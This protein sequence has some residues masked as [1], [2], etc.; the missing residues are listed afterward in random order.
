VFTNCLFRANYA[1]YEGG[2]TWV[3]NHGIAMC[4]FEN[5]NAGNGGGVYGIR[6]T[7]RCS[8]FNGNSCFGLGGG[9]CLQDSMIDRCV[10]SNNNAYGGPAGNGGGLCLV[11]NVIA[12]QCLVVSNH[13]AYNGGGI[14]TIDDG[15][16]DNCTICSNAAGIEG[17]GVYTCARSFVQNGIL[18]F[19]EPDN[20]TN[21]STD[22]TYQNCCAT[23][24]ITG[25]ADAGG[26]TNADPLFA[27]DYGLSSLSPCREAG[28]NMPWMIG[29]N[30]LAGNPRI[31][32][33]GAVVDMGAYEFVPEPAA[34]AAALF[35]IGCWLKRQRKSASRSAV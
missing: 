12:L 19:N 7:I 25:A 32:P 13:A 34:A 17:G 21:V 16:L 8:T 15:V 29:A 1:K 23:P 24:K 35:V 26:N 10:A 2:G 14:Y 30:D 18:Y 11:S 5:N 4:T 27:A 9:A 6:S 28:T 3:S 31:L 20:Y 33:M 22:A